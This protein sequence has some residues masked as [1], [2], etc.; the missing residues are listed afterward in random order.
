MKEKWKPVKGY[1]G[2]YE[3]S[4]HGRVKSCKRTVVMV[5]KG[6]TIERVYQEKI[7]SPGVQEFYHNVTLYRNG[8]GKNIL[9]HRLV[10]Q[11]FLKPPRDPNMIVMHKDDDGHNNMMTNLKWGTQLDNMRDKIRKG[12]DVVGS[13]LPQ[14]TITERT[15]KRIARR[16]TAGTGPTAISRE[17]G[18]SLGVIWGIKDGRCWSHIT[19]FKPTR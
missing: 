6:R 5:I 2:S 18:V 8:K 15:A 17:L 9:V 12:R 3:I 4:S 1:E 7:M 16:L 14:A 11:A 13:A 19:G 10:A